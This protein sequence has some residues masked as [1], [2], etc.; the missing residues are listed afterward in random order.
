[1]SETVLKV[2]N[3]TV[4]HGQL[5]AVNDVSF[6]V[7]SGEVFAII[8]ANGAGKSTLLRS[9]AGLQQSTSG[10]IIWKGQDI[11]KIRAHRRVELGVSLVPEGRRLFSSMTLLENLQVGAFRAPKGPFSI[12]KIFEIFPWMPERR[13]QQ[14]WQFSGGEQQAIA[15]SRALVRNPQLLMIDELSLGLAP[16]IVERIY[17]HIPAIV[18]EGVSVLIVEQDVSQATAV[19]SQ[20]HCLLE[21]HTAL[22]GKPSELS[23]Q[24][25]EKAYF[26]AGLGAESL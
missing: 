25:I 2:E 26:G 14:A 8:G 10:N 3:L 13:R 20:I 12:E 16:I 19:A 17:S 21:G 18:K 15:I 1:M 6:S 24:E 5:C 11:S 23:A 9:I 22:T 4:H 7:E